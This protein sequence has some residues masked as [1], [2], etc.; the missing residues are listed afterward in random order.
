ME[1]AAHPFCGTY[2]GRIKDELQKAKD[3]RLLIEARK[4]K[5][6]LARTIGISRDV[7]QIAVIEDDGSIILLNNTFDL[8]NTLLRFTPA[9]SGAYTIG[10][11]SGSLNP[12]FG[13]RIALADDAYQ[14]IA[15]QGFQFP[16]F[17]SN[18]SS[19][20][21]NS[22]GNLTF[23]EGDDA[24]TD[25]GI[26]RFNSGPPRIGGFFA[27][28]NPEQSAGGIYYNRLSDR[29]L[30]T[31]NRIR[32]W[33]GSHEGSF[34]IAL[35]PD[36]SFELTYGT[37]NISSGIVGWTGGRD[38]QTITIVDLSGAS[39]TLSGPQAER[40]SET[41]QNEVEITASV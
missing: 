31:W 12:D 30:I 27:D 34:Q 38:A 25:R 29:L 26:T 36:G 28:L 7:G 17:G 20:F 32:E 10:R 5:L 23:A 4:K 24:I 41:N 35:F 37:V 2:P 40:F 13:T 21:V 16:F 39:G 18:Y 11:Q 33:G 9:G 1:G 22:D 3:L 19:V 15:F 6:G 8:S 14:Q